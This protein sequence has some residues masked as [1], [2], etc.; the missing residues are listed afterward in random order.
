MR[1]RFCFAA[2]AL[3]GFAQSYNLA[4]ITSLQRSYFPTDVDLFVVG[5]RSSIATS[6]TSFVLARETGTSV[7]APNPTFADSFGDVYFYG[8]RGQ[9]A[10]GMCEVAGQPTVLLCNDISSSSS[11]LSSYVSLGLGIGHD[12]A[13]DRVVGTTFSNITNHRPA[14]FSISTGSMVWSSAYPG[15]LYAIDGAPSRAVGYRN[16]NGLNQA[17]LVAIP[18]HTMTILPLGT[19][20]IEAIAKGIDDGGLIVGQIRTS[21]GWSA[22]AWV[23]NNAGGYHP[24]VLLP[25]LGSGTDQN[26]VA[27][28]VVSIGGT[29]SIVGSSRAADGAVHGVLWENGITSDAN[30]G[31]FSGWPSSSHI[32]T[33]LAAIGTGGVPPIC[34]TGNGGAGVYNTEP[35]SLPGGVA[36]GSI[37]FTNAPIANGNGLVLPDQVLRGSTTAYAGAGYSPSTNLPGN[38]RPMSY[39]NL[40]VSGPSSCFFLAYDSTMWP[41]GS[42]ASQDYVI[43]VGPGNWGAATTVQCTLSATQLIKKTLL[44]P[45]FGEVPG[46]S[47]TVHVPGLPQVQKVSVEVRSGLANT[48]Q[49]E[50]ARTMSPG[51]GTQFYS[52]VSGPAR[53]SFRA[54]N[55]LRTTLNVTLPATMSPVLYAGDLDGNNVID[56]SDYL[57]LVSTFDLTENDPGFDEDVDLDQDGVI[58]LSDYLVL[59]SNMDRVGDEP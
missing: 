25:K 7:G 29:M 36:I 32:V 9:S 6:I 16:F 38:L 43:Q 44:R 13:G 55:T 58:G 46:M 19:Q 41:L 42:V 5:Y 52:Q 21:N 54:K 26:E 50:F 53:V 22:C 10:V 59:V 45:G 56:L 17:I 51:I 2:L 11:M 48:L 35:G 49:E 33:K 34:G 4:A 18:S 24:P 57:M 30:G 28:D 8:T 1:H 47:L 31:P 14:I 37:S 23:P 39:S 3:A 20:G 15:A 12:I 40:L 27:E